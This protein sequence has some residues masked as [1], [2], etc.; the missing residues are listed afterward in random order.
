MTQYN[1]TPLEYIFN[2]KFLQR[3]SFQ[4]TFATIAFAFAIFKESKSEYII[5]IMRK[6]NSPNTFKIIII[7]NSIYAIHTA[8]TIQILLDTCCNINMNV[9]S[10]LFS[11]YYHLVYNIILSI[12]TL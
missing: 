11:V 7:R 9:E 8:Y 3:L 10:E 6:H 2:A 12:Q 5:Y 1:V 4:Y